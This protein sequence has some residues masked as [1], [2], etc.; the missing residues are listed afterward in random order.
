MLL[1]TDGSVIVQQ[2]ESNNW[3]HLTPDKKGNYYDGTWSQIASMPSNYAPTYYASAVLPDGRVIVEGGEYNGG[4]E[5][6][7]T[8]GEIY[9]PRANTWTAV[10]PPTG[11]G[12]SLIGDAPS[13]V[14]AN[15]T[16]MLGSCCSSS[17]ALLNENTLTWTATGTGAAF[18]NE[19]GWSLLPNGDV[20]TTV[21][22]QPDN[23]QIYSPGTG[24]W[25]DA[26][27]PPAPLVNGG[28][29][30]P[31]LLLPDGDVFA[32]GANGASDIYDTSTGTWSAGPSFP[33]IG[34]QQYDIADG[35]SAVLPDGNVLFEAS[36]GQ[37]SPAHFFQWNGTTLTQVA[38][39]PNANIQPSY[40][41]RMLVLPTGRI[42]FD[43]LGSLEL[44][45]DNGL[46]Q[47]TWAPQIS[48]V[49]TRLR[50]G[51]TYTVSGIQLNGLTQG[52]AYG[53]D[54]Q[55]AT[56]FPMVRIT[57]DKTGDESYARTFGMT[58]MSVAPGTHSSANFRLPA[59]IDTGASTLEVI[60]NGI[61]S[62][63]VKVWVQ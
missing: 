34:G 16:F 9:D 25:T 43:D 55:S 33:V 38:D 12:W 3:W 2:T 41:G 42:L 58:S 26:G 10:P 49:P 51:A 48:K 40:T 11:S 21:A 50:T 63:P 37:Q 23:T 39:S 60:A 17:D 61:A 4:Q 62:T 24:A 22:S 5:T 27:N 44:Y 18:N 7:T 59:R 6:D 54:Y 46:P 15:G 28:E 20:L 13:T 14:L 57:N 8:Q 47:A 35:P 56:N 36:P 1:L 45:S 29:V 32:A 31:Q 53:D 19:D 52:S 30:G